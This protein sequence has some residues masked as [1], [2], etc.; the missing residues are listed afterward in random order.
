MSESL[1]WQPVGKRGIA[2][3]T[4]ENHPGSNVS[5]GHPPNISI[6]ETSQYE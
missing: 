4:D 5:S 2:L 6:F 1:P 3:K